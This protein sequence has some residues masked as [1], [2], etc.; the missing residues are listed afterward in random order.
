MYTLRGF[1]VFVSL[2]MLLLFSFL[3]EN[4]TSV[5]NFKV[6]WNSQETSNILQTKNENTMNDSDLHSCEE[7]TNKENI[8]QIEIPIIGLIAPIEEGT[9]KEIMDEFVGHFE[10]TAVE[11]G[12]IGLIAHNRG[13]PKNYFQNI[14]ELNIGDKIY[15]TYQDKTR[16][17]YVEN[18]T[19]IK[20]T[21]WSY[22]EKTEDNR[23]TLITCVENE[24]EYRRC[25]QGIEYP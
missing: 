16:V 6:K 21:D 23:I 11:Q 10:H 2:V 15:Y 13:Y 9:T 7:N 14:K 19:V 17:Y 18:I 1:S 3:E 22:L 5:N 12:N 4:S 8:W 20:E 24:P 25:I